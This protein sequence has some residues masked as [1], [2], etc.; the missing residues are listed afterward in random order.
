MASISDPVYPTGPDIGR[1]ADDAAGNLGCGM[2]S[3]AQRIRSHAPQEGPVA[4]AADA[5]ADTLDSGGRYLETEGVSGMTEDVANIIR[6]NPMPALLLG[7][8]V[9]YLL[10]RA[11]RR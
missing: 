2:K 4:T 6:K 11:L 8:G 9:G 7:L 5:L 1:R 10:A 3:L